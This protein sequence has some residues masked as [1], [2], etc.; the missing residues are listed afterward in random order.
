MVPSASIAVV[1]DDVPL[2]FN[3][4]RVSPSRSVSFARTAIAVNAS[5]SVV[6]VSFAATGPSFAAVTVTVTVAGVA[7][8]CPYRIVYRKSRARCS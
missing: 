3:T 5:S 6:A 4:E 2:T 7:P 1:P 8:A